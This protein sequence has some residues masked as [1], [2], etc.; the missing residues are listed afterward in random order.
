MRDKFVIASTVL[1]SVLLVTA[2]FSSVVALPAGGNGPGHGTGAGGAASESGGGTHDRPTGMSPTET[3]Q[4]ESA[5]P[6]AAGAPDSPAPTPAS[7]TTP[8]DR[9][10]LDESAR[11]SDSPTCA[12]ANGG[13]YPVPALDEDSRTFRTDARDLLVAANRTCDRTQ[14]RFGDLAADLNETLTLY[15]DGD[16][17]NDGRV[18]AVDKHV[19]TSTRGQAPNVTAAVVASD[20]QLAHTSVA[21]AE[22]VAATLDE[23]N[24]SYDERAVVRQLR[25]AGAA[26]DRGDRLRGQAV[27]AITQYRNAWAHAQRALDLMDEAVEPQVS[28]ETRE[29]LPHNESTSIS[30]NATVF[31]VRGYELTATVTVNGTSEQLE[32]NASSRPGDGV[33]FNDTVVLDRQTPW[34]NAENSV[35][36]TYVIVA[37]ASDPGDDYAQTALPGFEEIHSSQR[38]STRMLLDGDG[39][40]DYYE[41]GVLGTDPLD[42]N[43]NATTTKTNESNDGN[44]DGLEDHDDDG[45]ISYHEYLDGLNPLDPDTDGDNVTDGTEYETS[46]LDP[47]NPDTDDD[48]TSDGVEDLDDD[49]LSNAR[50]DAEATDLLNPDTDGDGLPDNETVAY[51]TNPSLADTDSDGLSDYEEVELGTDTLHPDSDGD[52]VRDGS[53]TFTTSTTEETTGVSLTVRGTGF[54]ADHMSINPR[55]SYHNDSNVSAGPTVYVTNQSAFQGGTIRLPVDEDVNLRTQDVSI[56]RWNPSSGD[57]WEPVKTQIDR[58]NRTAVTTF[59][60]SSYFAVLDR[61]AWNRGTSVERPAEWPFTEDFDDLSGWNCSGTCQVVDGNVVI[62]GETTVQ[63]T[64]SFSIFRIPFCDIDP[65]PHCIPRNGSD[66]T[67]DDGTEDDGTEDGETGGTDDEES[68]EEPVSRQHEYSR[69]VTIDGEYERIT[70]KV[71]AYVNRSDEDSTGELVIRGDDGRERTVALDSGGFVFREIDISGYDDQTITSK[72]VTPS[73]GTITPVAFNITRDTDGDGIRDHIEEQRWYLARGPGGWFEL[74]KTSADTDG[75]GLRDGREV[76]FAYEGAGQSYTLK[77]ARGN[78]ANRNTDG[79]GLPDGEELDL[80]SNV[81]EPETLSVSAKIPT[82]YTVRNGRL[83]AVTKPASIGSDIESREVPVSGAD[84]YNTLDKRYIVFDKPKPEW[85]QGHGIEEATDYYRLEGYVQVAV[86]EHVRENLDMYQEDVPYNYDISFP[87][88]DVRIVDVDI[89]NNGRNLGPGIHE[90]EV[91]IEQSSTNTATTDTYLD[92]M[93][94][95]EVSMELTDGDWPSKQRSVFYHDHDSYQSLEWGAN[96]AT[97]DS[98]RYGAQFNSKQQFAERLS[99][100]GEDLQ[101]LG[102]IASL[103][104]TTI[105]GTAFYLVSGSARTAVVAAALEQSPAALSKTGL[106]SDADPVSIIRRA[107][108]GSTSAFLDEEKLRELKNEEE[109]T[110]VVLPSGP[111]IVLQN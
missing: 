32:L 44:I 91:V 14:S 75:D 93:A 18:F 65:T 26:L 24:V 78:P 53:E 4:A 41:R 72:F 21:D 76:S 12:R 40:P 86:S 62:G 109:G 108:I 94:S 52:G 27:A 102:V 16:R 22:R 79:V 104:T 30:I 92:S 88:S 98:A 48:G 28:I 46:E 36:R 17:V 84:R 25:K 8:R 13:G 15:R 97:F 63:S 103:Q 19:A 67:E 111:H 38:G 70:V 35:N 73:G 51:G 89:E 74:D 80:G 82:T 105:T 87:S 66:G 60:S 99:E 33:V 58:R 90:L 96:S 64:D 83:V 31:D 23:R 2:S 77:S 101:T 45:H 29:D 7:T 85:L 47:S 11:G 61:D 37:T 107:Y 3:P 42:P 56:F 100:G 69:T 5:Q 49:G 57:P 20:A 81:F 54:T 39:L 10:G 50:E 106:A 6:N 59:S 34:P 95:M 68:S 71:G 55:P 1:F 110:T 43:S 9:P